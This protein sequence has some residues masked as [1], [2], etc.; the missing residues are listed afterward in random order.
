MRLIANEV[1]RFFAAP[2]VRIPPSP[3]LAAAGSGAGGSSRRTRPRERTV[4]PPNRAV[5]ALL[6]ASVLCSCA[7]KRTLTITSEPP[8]A[9]VRLDDEPLGETPLEVEFLHYGTRRVSYSLDGYLT[10][11]V[12]IE[13]NAPWFARFPI[14]IFSEVLLPVG[15]RDDHAVH[16]SLTPGAEQLQPPALRSV[17]ERAEALRRAGPTGPR[18]LPPRDMIDG[19]NEAGGT[20]PA[21]RPQ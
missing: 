21:D 3:P 14:D 6:A 10:R 4:F 1:S 12:L 19:P 5:A 13:V 15:W 8:G 16:A 2:R 9:F 11:S 17:L 7:A 18:E 20:K